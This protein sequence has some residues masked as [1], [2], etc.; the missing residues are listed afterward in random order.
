MLHSNSKNRKTVKDKSKKSN[1]VKGNKK[2]CLIN[3]KKHNNVKDKNKTTAHR[4]ND[5]GK[6]STQVTQDNPMMAALEEDGGA[7]KNKTEP[8][9]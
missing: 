9:R 7:E 1:H 4:N 2:H 3:S 8:V 6:Q 5:Q